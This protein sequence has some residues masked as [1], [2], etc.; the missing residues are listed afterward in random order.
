[1]NDIRYDR[2]LRLWGEEGQ[3]SIEQTSVCLLGASALG[4]EIMKSLV[5]AGVHAVCI[6]DDAVV[7]SSDLGHNFFL[8]ESDLGYIRVYVKEH[9]IANNHEENPRVDLR[10]AILF[11]FSISGD[12]SAFPD[13][14]D[15]RKEF[16][17]VL[18]SMRRISES[19]FSNY[20]NFDEAKAAL[21]RS[22]QKTEISNIIRQTFVSHNSH[23]LKSCL[24][25]HTR[26]ELLE[27]I[28]V[29]SMNED[30]VSPSVWFILLRAADKFCREK[31]RYPGTN[32][33][34]CSIDAFDLRQRVISLLSAN[35]ALDTERLMTSISENA[36]KEMCRYGAGEPHV[37]ASFIG[38]VM[39]GLDHELLSEALADF[40]YTCEDNDLF[41]DRLNRISIQYNLN[42][43]DLVDELIASAMNLKRKSIDC[44]LIDLMEPELAKRL[45]K[46][47]DAA[48]T[49]STNKYRRPVLSERAPLNYSLTDVSCM[50][51]DTYMTEDIGSTQLTGMYAMFAPFRSTPSNGK[52]QSR[53]DRGS[54]LLAIKGEL[55]VPG[56]SDS[57]LQPIDVEI[58]TEK[59]DSKYA[60]DKIANVIEAKYALLRDWEIL[61]QTANPDVNQW[62]FPTNTTCETVFIY[63]EVL[64]DM[65]ENLPMGDTTISLLLNKEDISIIR[66]DL[67]QLPE[68]SLFPGQVC[69]ILLLFL[70]LFSTVMTSF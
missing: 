58:V 43:D 51:V 7:T 33:V 50:E 14:Y 12:P 27:N 10:L 44:A 9:T 3:L 24:F 52:F 17:S 70:F 49:L 63:G 15:K 6:I 30:V 29:S 16:L 68:I 64:S 32:G 23:L 21:A 56:P 36:I 57:R 28:P 39:N 41:F 59:V 22:L 40:G 62:S 20:D 61:F 38:V 31:G 2:Q 26:F 18:W 48:L 45:K 11:Y 1:M 35:Q 8:R 25:I 54:V 5:L 46:N 34:P 60:N 66:L 4:T 65:N 42:G 13:S 69:A 53:T 19:D 47:L 67:S 55:F 37:V